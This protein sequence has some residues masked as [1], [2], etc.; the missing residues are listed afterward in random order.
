MLRIGNQ[1]DA[2][3]RRHHPAGSRAQGVHTAAPTVPRAVWTG[4]VPV[5]GSFAAV[6]T[7]STGVMSHST[8]EIV[9]G[10]LSIL[11]VGLVTAMIF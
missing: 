3:T 7:Y 8:Q 1:A 10:V 5:A 9:G 4:A 2:R 11:A 6:P